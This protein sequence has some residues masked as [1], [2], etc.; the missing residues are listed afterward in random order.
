MFRREF[1]Y[2]VLPLALP[3]LLG[4]SWPGLLG[5]SRASFL[6]ILGQRKEQ[7]EGFPRGRFQAPHEGPGAQHGREG[8]WP[9]SDSRPLGSQTRRPVSLFPPVL[10]VW[11]QMWAMRPGGRSAQSLAQ[12]VSGPFL[13]TDKGAGHTGMCPGLR[14]PWAKEPEGQ[15]QGAT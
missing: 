12:R 11:W 10:P 5:L 6:S 9:G 1:W 15:S 7:N 2:R 4:I 14:V 13:S 8:S 3:T